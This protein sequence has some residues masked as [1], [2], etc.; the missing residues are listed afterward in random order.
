MLFALF[1]PLCKNLTL[2]GPLVLILDK[3]SNIMLKYVMFKYIYVFKILRQTTVEQS[4][5]EIITL[6]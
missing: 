2:S 1:L 3:N 6:I 4:E 5:V